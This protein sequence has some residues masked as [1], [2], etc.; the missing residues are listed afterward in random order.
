LIKASIYFAIA[1]FL[2]Q[3]YWPVISVVTNSI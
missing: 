1:P 2:T 3:L